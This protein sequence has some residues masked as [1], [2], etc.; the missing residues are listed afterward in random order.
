MLDLIPITS[1]T[2]DNV[3]FQVLNSLAHQVDHSLV[4]QGIVKD[5]RKML[6]TIIKVIVK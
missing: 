1:R 2:I 5:E 4:S 3:S 6:A